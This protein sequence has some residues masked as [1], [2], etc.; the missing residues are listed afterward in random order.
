MAILSIHLL[1]TFRLLDGDRPLTA[2]QKPRLQALL[3]YLLL[4]R[5]APVPRAR[6]AALFWPDTTDAQARTN[7][8]NLI[9]ALREALPPGDYLL[10]DTQTIGWNPAAAFRLDVADFEAA[11]AAADPA[12]LQAAAALYSDDLLPELYDDWAAAERDRL[13]ALL[14]GALARLA[15][16]L[17]SDGRHAEAITAANRLLRLDPLHEPATVRLMRLNALA[18]DRA[19]V[20][21]AYDTLASVL[22]LEVGVA[23]AAETTAAYHHW[24]STEAA[25]RRPAARAALPLPADTLFGRETDVAAVAALVAQHRLVSLTGYGGVGKTRL[26]L[27]A[28]ATLAEQFADGAC[29]VDLA[30]LIESD[31]VVAAAGAALSLLEQPG[32]PP[33]ATLVDYLAARRLLLIL[34]NCEHVLVGAGAL[35]TAIG[36]DCPGVHV[37]ATS[38]LRLRLPGEHVFQVRPL[39]LPQVTRDAL[40]ATSEEE[41]VAAGEYSAEEVAAARENPSVQLFVDRATAVWPTFALT[42]RNTPA[43]VHVCRRLEGIPLAIELAAGRVRLLS[44]RQIAARL[45]SAFDLLTAGP[46]QPLAH[47][48]LRGVLDWSYDL[49]TAGEKML[50]RRLAVFAGSFSLEAAEAIGGGDPA[51]GDDPMPRD[52]TLELLAGLIDHSLVAGEEGEDERRYRLH[53]M[54]R[55]YALEQLVAAGEREAIMGRLLAYVAALARRARDELRGEGQAGWLRRLDAKAPTIETALEWG[56]RAP[57]DAAVADALRAVAEL[58][59]YWTLRGRQLYAGRLTDRVLAAAAGRSLPPDAPAQAHV[60]AAALAIV[61]TDSAAAAAHLAAA[62]VD[63]AALDD[64]YTGLAHHVRGLIAYIARDHAAAEAIWRAALDATGTDWCRAILLDDLGNVYMRLDQPERALAVFQE[65]RAIAARIGDRISR[66][67]ALTNLGIVLGRLGEA[68]DA[69]AYADEAV[70]LARRMDSPRLIAYA[71]RNQA[72]LALAAGDAPTAYTLL[73][74]STALAWEIRNRDLTLSALE[75]LALAAARLRPDARAVTLLGAVDAARAAFRLPP[76]PADEAAVLAARAGL[77]EALPPATFARAWDEG[78]RLDWV[79]VVAMALEE[80]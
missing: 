50:L 16:R 42:P 75:Q 30:P 71:L 77:A 58:Y 68:D 15:D 59:F 64:A 19:G 76:H 60:T 73:R 9:H 7:L 65:E 17:E 23:P 2:L 14:A 37:L 8:R 35:I 4:H 46:T 21:R 5:A 28:A 66:F 69:R 25:P 67:Y 80:E 54:T 63:P 43:V 31:A 72:R 3:A 39:A 78:Q 12:G 24:L 33:L 11:C 45:D 79:E 26:A 49:L 36:R 70:G 52:A 40:R 56:S 34:D 55:Q 10:A 32:R 62:L 41:R 13:R 18:G 53:E 74:E 22:R 6:L 38:R 57:T 29:W 61:H 51:Q 27:A 47:R 48:T 20:R 44:T 1:G